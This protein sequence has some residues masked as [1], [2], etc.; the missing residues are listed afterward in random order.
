MVL[1]HS[2][3]S[4]KSFV[5]RVLWSHPDWRGISAAQR[6]PSFHFKGRLWSGLHNDCPNATFQGIVNMTLF[7]PGVPVL[8]AAARTVLCV[9][10][11]ERAGR[12][13]VRNVSRLVLEVHVKG[14][15]CICA[16]RGNSP[17]ATLDVLSHR[18]TQA[19]AFRCRVTVPYGP[20][21]PHATPTG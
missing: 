17:R 6:S 3:I 8:D 10:T 9:V 16:P 4:R 7:L 18:R 19:C 2:L 21:T 11:L 20:I 14:L 15:C 5:K 13:K 12:L 1:L